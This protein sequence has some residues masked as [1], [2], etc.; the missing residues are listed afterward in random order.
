M[1][2][3][4]KIDEQNHQIGFEDVKL[5]IQNKKYL[6]VNTLSLTDQHCL[7]QN[8]VHAKNEET[9]INDCILKDDDISILLYG[10]NATDITPNKKYNQFK[11]LGFDHV[12]IYTGGLFEWLLLQNIYGESEFPTTSICKDL[13]Q[14]RPLSVI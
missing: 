9:I 7:I 4:A 13:L 8:T 5:A 6:I 10:R 11:K 14:Y 2:S 12:Y 3:S 1:N